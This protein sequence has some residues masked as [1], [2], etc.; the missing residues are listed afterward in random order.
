MARAKTPLRICSF[1][2]AGNKLAR[3]LILGSMPGEASL[4][5]NQYYAHP[6]NHFWP[7]MGEV[8][9]AYPEL[10][11][12]ERLA[13]LAKSGVIMWESLQSCLRQGSLDSAIEEE[14]PNDFTTFLAEHPRVTHV[15]FNGAKAEQSFRK[16]VL[17][18]LKNADLVFQLLPSTSPAHAG[19]S[20][21]QKLEIW[22]AAL[23]AAAAYKKTSKS[24]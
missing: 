18:T 10:P 6:R 5:A 2:P 4:A 22:R 15:F 19:R 21:H 9:G 24:I 3:I 16:H 14:L 7:I 20:L 12:K 23:D 1:P 13:V 8:F 17:P 11:Y